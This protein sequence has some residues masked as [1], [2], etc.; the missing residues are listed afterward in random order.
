MILLIIVRYRIVRHYKW[1][2]AD[3]ILSARKKEGPATALIRAKT[4]WLSACNLKL[5]GCVLYKYL[6]NAN[7]LSKN[8]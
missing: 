5:S 8:T 4:P 2:R 3:T 7:I 1:C 6:A